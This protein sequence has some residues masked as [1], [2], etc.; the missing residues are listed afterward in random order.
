[1]SKKEM[2]RAARDAFPKAKGAQAKR[3]TGGAYS[4]RKHTVSTRP[5]ARSTAPKPPSLR[6]SIIFGVAAAAFYFVLIQWV[7]RVGD[8]SVT[9]NLIIAVVGLFLFAGIN[10]L[11]EGFRYRR[12][13]RKKDSGG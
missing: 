7:F 4:K 3:S 13:L 8:S 11:T 2:R 10:Y 5:G 1:M 12:Y 6:R 9:T